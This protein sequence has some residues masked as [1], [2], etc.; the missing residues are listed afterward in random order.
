[1]SFASKCVHR[2]ANGRY[3][4]Q[5]LD[6]KQEE[7]ISLQERFPPEQTSRIVIANALFHTCCES[8]LDVF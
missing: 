8:L 1:V 5:S 2:G 6:D 3:L 7:S 4:H